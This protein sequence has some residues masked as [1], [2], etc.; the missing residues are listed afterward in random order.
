MLIKKIT[1]N[2]I[3]RANSFDDEKFFKLQVI[4]MLQLGGRLEQKKLK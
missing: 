1:D 3:E 4:V 2:S